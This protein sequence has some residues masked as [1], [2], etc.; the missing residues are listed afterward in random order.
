MNHAEMTRRA[1]AVDADRPWIENPTI[2]AMIRGYDDRL[3]IYYDKSIN[4]YCVARRGDVQTHF[5]A[6]WQ[7]EQGAFLPIDRRLFEAVCRW[8]MRPPRLDAEKSADALAAKMDAEDIARTEK[9]EK[10]FE[11]DVDH[12]TKDNKRVIQ[13]AIDKVV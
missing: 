9:L 6:V 7:D 2:M 3:F 5:I 1:R 11:D 4:R 8:D 10:D 12:L 13:K